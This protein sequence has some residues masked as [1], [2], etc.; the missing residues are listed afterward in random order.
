MASLREVCLF[1]VSLTVDGSLS[2]IENWVI[3]FFGSA[4]RSGYHVCI[5][6]FCARLRHTQELNHVFNAYYTG[7]IVL[8]IY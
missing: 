1:Q 6:L 3:P 2:G 8:H 7:R 5:L 4:A